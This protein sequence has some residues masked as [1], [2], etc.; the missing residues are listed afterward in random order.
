MN[1]MVGLTDGRTD[2]GTD[3][4]TDRW[5]DGLGNGQSDLQSRDN[6]NTF[7]PISLHQKICLSN[8]GIY[9]TADG[10]TLLIIRTATGAGQE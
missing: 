4:G 6:K 10:W 3:G 8:R 1:L 5:R 2:G 7:W 9:L